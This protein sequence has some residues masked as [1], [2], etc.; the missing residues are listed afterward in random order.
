MINRVIGENLRR[1]R[2]ELAM[3]LD[4]MA[5]VTGVSKSM[6]GQIEREEVNPTVSTVW[7]IS[8]ALR[9]PLSSILEEPREEV[10]MV[11]LSET[12]A[13]EGL[14]SDFSL[15]TIFPFDEQKR[16]E[17]FRKEMNPGARADSKGHR[18]AEYIFVICGQLEVTVDGSVYLLKKMDS[19]KFNAERPHSYRNSGKEKMI[20]Y[21][22]FH[23]SP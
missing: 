5:R 4:D 9:I 2:K 3:S 22:L 21:T 14:S 6:L 20:C 10:R 19:L 18:A 17:I 1:V 8:N 23:Y 16:F 11:R 13:I 12:K 15:F 7:K